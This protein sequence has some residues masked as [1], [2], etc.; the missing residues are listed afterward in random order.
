MP[1]NRNAHAASL[2]RG[3]I[4]HP[5]YTYLVTTVIADRR[6]LLADLQTAR[7]LVGEMREACS[8]GSV[9]SLAWVVMPDHLHWLLTLQQGSLS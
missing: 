9:E 6:P 7:L 2:R 4:S 3:R 5:G 8:A 1:D